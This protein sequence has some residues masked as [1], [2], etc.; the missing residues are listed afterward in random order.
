M[1]ILGI[2]S[3]AIVLACW[4]VPQSH[5]ATDQD[6]DLAC[7]VVSAAEIAT[8]KEAKNETPRSKFSFFILAG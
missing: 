6:F 4:E 8:T 3:L 5:A 1:R 2:G 7:T